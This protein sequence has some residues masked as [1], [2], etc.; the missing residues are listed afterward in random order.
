[1]LNKFLN[2]VDSDFDQS[3]AENMRKKQQE[4]VSKLLAKLGSQDNE[5]DNLNGCSILQ[6]M[7]ETKEFYGIASKKQN[8]QTL[9]DFILNEEG[10]NASRVASASILVSLCQLFHD[11]HRGASS[12]KKREGNGEE[13]DDMTLQHSDEEEGDEQTEFPLVE[14][15]R[16]HGQ[17]LSSILDTTPKDKL[18]GTF[19]R[20]Q[21][22]PLGSL[23][24]KIVE[25][26][27]FILKL[28]KP[29]LYTVVVETGTLAKI[30]QLL[31][32][33]PWNNFL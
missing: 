10:T 18:E 22:V 26:F 11:K 33:N 3:V 25:L 2:I 30:S 12:K 17:A 21:Y 20:F 15:L 4:V 1:L 6:D 27:M 32:V 19:D 8:I 9:I 14:V 13:D 5:E 29:A 24:L 16:Q 7:L 31:S 23:R 28:H